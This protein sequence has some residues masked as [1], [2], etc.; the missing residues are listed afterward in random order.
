MLMGFQGLFK[1]RSMPGCSIRLMGCGGRD[2]FSIL[3]NF[4]RYC[5]MSAFAN[6]DDWGRIQRTRLYRLTA[7][8]SIEQLHFWLA[9]VSGHG[10][11]DNAEIFDYSRRSLEG[12]PLAVLTHARVNRGQTRFFWSSV[13]GIRRCLRDS[14]GCAFH[15]GFGEHPLLTLATF[16]VWRDL[17][18]MQA[19]AYSQTAHH[20][21]VKTA[22][23]EGW[24]AE[25]IFVRFEIK[26]VTGDLE[27]FPKLKA[28]AQ[29]GLIPT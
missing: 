16:S 28:L 8:P 6:P 18:S 2:G 15:I 24:L 29:V 17:P 20:R 13:P 21:A 10:T 19:F 25:S 23:G 26:Q 1:E 12:R 7:G 22:R 11:W 4:N 14:E 5:L 27:H 9:P 3:P